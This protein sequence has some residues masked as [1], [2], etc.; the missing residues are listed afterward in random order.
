MGV[1]GLL[2]FAL[3][4]PG[5]SAAPA[6]DADDAAARFA[7]EYPAALADRL[8]FLERKLDLPRERM[9]RLAGAPARF[10]ADAAVAREAWAALVT[11]QS[12][13]HRDQLTGLEETL[14]D[15]LSEF[16]H[17][18]HAAA[19][20]LR[21]RRTDAAPDDARDDELL[22]LLDDG[23]GWDFFDLMTEFLTRRAA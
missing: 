19:A 7:R 6:T 11:Q 2:R 16:N 4:N 1:F 8:D 17:D 15:Y 18:W 10:A 22:A 12:A 3:G 9:L 23:T 5:L 21:D 20:Y 13:A 14:A